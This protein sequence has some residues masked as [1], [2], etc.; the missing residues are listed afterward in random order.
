[1]PSRQQFAATASP[2][3]ISSYNS[4]IAT[5]SSS[6]KNH[7][8][9]PLLV[10]LAVGGSITAAIAFIVFLVLLY[11]KLRARR[12]NPYDI[13]SV[14]LQRFSYRDLKTATKSFDNA[15]KLGQG[16]F[17]AVYKG[18]LRNGQK[19]AVKVLDT[20]SLQGEREFQN[21]VSVI[22]KVSSPHI[23]GLMG[24]CADR[25]RRLLVY[26][27]M[28][29]RSLQDA[30]FD[31]GYPLHL[32]WGKRFGIILDTAK[33][34]AFLHTMCDPAIIH[35]DIKPS[36]ILLDGSFSAR[37]ADFGLARL[38]TEGCVEDAAE[39]CVEIRSDRK[40]ME[41]ERR[42]HRRKERRKIEMNRGTDD[43]SVKGETDSVDAYREVCAI[44]GKIEETKVNIDG[45]PV[46][47]VNFQ[48]PETFVS[49]S[50]KGPQSPEENPVFSSNTSP[51]G[52][53]DETDT[54]TETQDERTPSEIVDLEKNM[55]EN[56]TE[57]SAYATNTEPHREDNRIAFYGR[58]KDRSLDCK[59]TDFSRDEED[60]TSICLSE[61]YLDKMS[62][63][64]GKHGIPN[65][66]KK[67]S[68]G[69]DWWWKQ[70]NSGEFSVKDYVMEWIGTEI[71]KERPKISWKGDDASSD[72]DSNLG[73]LDCRKVDKRRT[74]SKRKESLE[75][76]TTLDEEAESEEPTKKEKSKSR[77]AK[78]KSKPREV[79][80]W[81][82][83]EYC[84]E[85]SNKNK[86][87]PKGRSR[88]RREKSKSR[89]W[90][91]E[92]LEDDERNNK[93]NRRDKN[94]SRSRDWCRE[95]HHQHHSGEFRGRSRDWGSGDL[96]RSGVSSTP[97]MR[98]TV[99]YVAPEYGGGG[100][101]SEKSDVYSFGVLMLVIISGRRPLQVMASPITEFERA[102]LISWARH[103]AQSGN[104][105][106]LVDATLGDEYDRDQAMLCITVAL[107]CLQR[108]PAARP[109][110]TEVVKFLSRE[111]EAPSLPFEFSPS[112]PYGIPFRSRR[113]ASSEK[114]ASDHPIP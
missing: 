41:K 24:F 67:N 95:D 101:L 40:A 51:E 90:W 96:L 23:V 74:Y 114:A 2:W 5:S 37:I 98:G 7:R 14:K 58:V 38:K 65:R 100:V 18:E 97:S 68:F 71:R 17:G 1:M 103:L 12:T 112:P 107:L 60:K 20:T 46:V 31:D 66:R 28:Q 39:Q 91:K 52:L 27:Y 83:E 57:L 10:G 104:V 25:K 9:T 48:S 6:S 88:S 110:M 82:K 45:D 8:N 32:D 92:D 62:L 61:G 78:E 33:A 99:C 102:N 80:E 63:D 34:L 30:L 11:R 84:E 13:A 44:N 106:D 22:G 86:N 79:R 81:W 26:E 73:S 16:G 76:W 105:L 21:E 85:L 3:T 69:R 89:E 72:Q 42:S 75:W 4:R 59:S 56:G 109:S 15:Q 64:S 54:I 53:H 70:E 77:E 87:S 29:N 49:S 111:T 113:K 93:K 36:N 19:I 55:S 108:L 47:L 94:K 35:G 50:S 43:K